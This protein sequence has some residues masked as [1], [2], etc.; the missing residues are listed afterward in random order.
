MDLNNDE[1]RRELKDI[2]AENTRRP[3]PGGRPGSARS[4]VGAPR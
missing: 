3:C 2:D 1:L 4:S